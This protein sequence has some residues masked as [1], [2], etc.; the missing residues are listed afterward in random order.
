M[1]RLLP[2]ARPSFLSSQRFS[3]GFNGT[4]SVRVVADEFSLL[5]KNRIDRSDFDCRTSD[6][7]EKGRMPVLKGG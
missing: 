6:L 3:Q 4:D 7:R 1:F 5:M 2:G